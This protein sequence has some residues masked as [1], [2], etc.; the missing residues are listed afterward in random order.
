VTVVAVVVGG[1]EHVRDTVRWVGG[2]MGEYHW[3]DVRSVEC[4]TKRRGAAEGGD[5]ESQSD[6]DKGSTFKTQ[7]MQASDPE[8]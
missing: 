3:V 2:W 4:G 8:L 5:D 7:S 6:T 1:H